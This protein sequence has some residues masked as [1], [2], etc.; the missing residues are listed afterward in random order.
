MAEIS[1]QPS[2][3]ALLGLLRPK[4]WIKNSFVLAPLIFAREF[5][6]GGSIKRALLAF[7]L[8]CVASSACYIVNDIHDIERDRRHPVKR[9]KRAPPRCGLP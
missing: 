4:Q 1:L 5:M 3:G 8:F 2:V 6:L 9:H 7:A